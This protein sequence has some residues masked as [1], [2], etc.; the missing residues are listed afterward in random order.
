MLTIANT[1]VDDCK[2]LGAL[3][4][5]PRVLQRFT[6]VSGISFQLFF[7]EGV[8]HLDSPVESL[9][10]LPDFFHPG[11]R[12]RRRRQARLSPGVAPVRPRTQPA[13]QRMPLKPPERS[14][15][16]NQSSVS[17]SKWRRPTCMAHRR[18]HPNHRYKCELLQAP[19]CAMRVSMLHIARRSPSL[20]GGQTK[21]RNVT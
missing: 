8:A 14:A 9:E 21:G 11:Q 20:T 6:L 3:T 17:E 7:A 16:A 1:D 19:A 2:P 10:S 18:G 13:T 15:T 4:A 5:H 12:L